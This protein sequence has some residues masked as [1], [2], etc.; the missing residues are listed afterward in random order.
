MKKSRK[1]DLRK[2]KPTE[3]Y[4]KEQIA[5]DLNRTPETVAR[6]KREGMPIIPGSS[7]YLVDGQELFDWLKKRQDA[8]KFPCRDN[9]AFC[10]TCKTQRTF[11][12]ESVVL[13][14][15]NSK[16]FSID[17]RCEEC[18]NEMH[19]GASMARIDEIQALLESYMQNVRYIER[20]R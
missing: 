17:S 7:P 13:R 9:E 4:N 8:R 10:F 11:E 14:P 2:I 1:V 15:I 20:Y 5:R 12:M 3:T 6:W 18:G 16:R 19:K